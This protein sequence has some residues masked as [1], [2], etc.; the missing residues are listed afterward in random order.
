MS[1]E[2]YNA[3]YQHR[4]PDEDYL[5][6]FWSGEQFNHELAALGV[7]SPSVTDMDVAEL[8]LPYLQES[9]L[10]HDKDHPP[11]VGDVLPHESLLKILAGTPFEDL[12]RTRAVTNKAARSHDV[13]YP[14]VDATPSGTN[15]MPPQ[16]ERIIG[17][18]V[19]C[20]MK[21]NS[22]G[23][24]LF[25]T[26]LTPEAYRSPDELTQ[27]VNYLFD[28][29]RNGRLDHKHGG[30][31]W[32]SALS[33]VHFNRMLAEEGKAQPLDKLDIIAITALIA[34]T[35]P[36]QPNARIENGSVVP[37]FM[38]KLG[39]RVRTLLLQMGYDQKNASNITNA[40]TALGVSM[41]NRDTSPFMRPNG[42]PLLIHG[43]RLLRA[44]E[45]I[46]G[47]RH[48]LRSLATTMSGLMRAARS[49]SSAPG[50]YRKI[51]R[52]EVPHHRVPKYVVP[53]DEQ[54]NLLSIEQSYP[55]QAMHNQAAHIVRENV[56]I[57]GT[58]FDLYGV[59]VSA[60]RCALR[61]GGELDSEV[62][63]SVNAR[64]WI[65]SMA[66]TGKNFEKL[67]QGGRGWS[68]Y[69]EFAKGTS[70]AAVGRLTTRESPLSALVLGGAGLRGAMKL[71]GLLQAHWDQADA[72]GEEDPYFNE[73]RAQAF[74]TALLDTV[75]APNY[76][77]ILDVLILAANFHNN[78]ARRERLEQRKVS[79]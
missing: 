59:G 34:A 23:D 61:L 33:E 77:T 64:V 67:K 11:Q 43:A 44:E 79:L 4:P 68:L 73:D 12:G 21:I 17:G 19:R 35:I 41:G 48:I 49:V 57:S 52:G 66:P 39:G 24:R 56:D 62:P 26:A 40:I 76:N 8:R 10:F 63:G 14:N 69:K 36:F 78:T 1:T 45:A 5:D 51:I 65:P 6:F 30:N 13:Y 71:A 2:V 16:L 18:I 27:L 47:D 70:Q 53:F 74:D 75:G 60:G 38:E 46:V 32:G 22:A 72:A 9:R 20:K 54:G 28:V 50:L 55:S 15:G 37:G 29:P 42:A 3:Y 7:T 25:E 31:E 58:F